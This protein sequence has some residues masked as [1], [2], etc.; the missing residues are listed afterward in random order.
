MLV[1]SNSQLSFWHRY[2]FEWHGLR[3]GGVKISTDVEAIRN[4]LGASILSNGY[5][6]VVDNCCSNPLANRSAWVGDL[7]TWTKVE[8]DLSSYSGQNALFR[9]RIGCD[10][11]VSD[12][13]WYIDDVQ[14]TAPLPPS[15]SPEVLGI[16]PNSGSTYGDTPVTIT[17]THFIPTPSARL[18]DTWL[19]SVTQISTTTLEAVV[20]A[21]IPG[22]T[23]TLTLYNG[24]CQ[25]SL[26][27]EAFT[28]TEEIIPISGLEAQNSSPTELGHATIFTASVAAGAGQLRVGFRRRHQRSWSQ[29]ESHLSC[30]GCIYG[31][32]YRHQQ[33]QHCSDI[34]PGNGYR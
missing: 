15:P 8:V 23:Y 11:S 7:T 22:G 28:I 5:N 1:G 30:A 14:I 34:H 21:G 3:W 2:Q 19:I 29:L 20:P 32:G 9:W 10:S 6:G 13:G 26:L 18:G 24:D 27:A 4:D 17:G 12:V 31:S 16:S 25:M 33:C